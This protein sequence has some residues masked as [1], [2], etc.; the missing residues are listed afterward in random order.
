MICVFDDI[1]PPPVCQG[2]VS[3][4]LYYDFALE[5]FWTGDITHA[6]QGERDNV[7]GHEDRGEPFRAHQRVCL[8]VCDE[9]DPGQFHVDARG[10]E[11]GCEQQQEFLDDEGRQCPVGRLFAAGDAANVADPFN[12]GGGRRVRNLCDCRVW[13]VWGKVVGLQ[14]P[15]ITKGMKYHVC[16][17]RSWYEWKAVVRMKRIVKMTAATV[18]G[19]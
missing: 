16:V 4:V 19:S 7:A 17:R 15:P 10:E 11:D 3:S 13:E 14:N 9:D 8:S 12:C 2:G 6:L 18:E 5:S 1:S